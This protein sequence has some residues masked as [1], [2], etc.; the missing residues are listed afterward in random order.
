MNVDIKLLRIAHLYQSWRQ[1]CH[2]VWHMLLL[3]QHAPLRPASM[4][5]AQADCVFPQCRSSA[6]HR[7]PFR[8]PSH[9]RKRLCCAGTGCACGAGSRGTNK[10]IVACSVHVGT[11]FFV[12]REHGRWIGARRRL[13][14]RGGCSNF[15]VCIAC[16]GSIIVVHNTPERKKSLT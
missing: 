11:R 8:P 16:G 3:L 1:R 7:S 10:S 12:D 2:S 9:P 15:R 14:C 13:R 6:S 4:Q 5:A